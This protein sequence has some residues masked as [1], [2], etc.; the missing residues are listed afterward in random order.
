MLNFNCKRHTHTGKILIHDEDNFNIK[1]QLK[2]YPSMPEPET[3]SGEEIDI[4]VY[5]HDWRQTGY[6]L[7]FVKR[8]A[9]NIYVRLKDY[10]PRITEI[11]TRLG[12]LESHF[13]HFR[14]LKR[15]E[16]KEWRRRIG[17]RE[18]LLIERIEN[19]EKEVINLKN[20]P[21]KPQFKNPFD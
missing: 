1:T 9:K 16:D 17:E 3:L 12:R 13:A 2:N 7:H 19:L 11:L 10:K 8:K 20:P 4:Y 18:K 15:K 5:P 6:D 21:L 14:K